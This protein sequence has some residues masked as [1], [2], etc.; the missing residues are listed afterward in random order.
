MTSLE[1]DVGSNE[2]TTLCDSSSNQACYYVHRV[3]MY[4]GR[5][6]SLR[7][8]IDKRTTNVLNNVSLKYMLYH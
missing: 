7:L 8:S 2:M 1:R 3:M 6:V 4:Y 5:L